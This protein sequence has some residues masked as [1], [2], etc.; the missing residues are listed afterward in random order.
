MPETK[1]ESASA[2]KATTVEKP[3]SVGV[4]I[5]CDQLGIDNFN[6]AFMHKFYQDKTM[7]IPA[8][9]SELKGKI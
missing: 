1:K 2:S 6:R 7:T 5:A 8:W 3:V 4:D 9:K